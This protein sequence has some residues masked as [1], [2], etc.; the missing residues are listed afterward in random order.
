MLQ[1]LENAPTE[2]LE[3]WVAARKL[4]P[5]RFVA[6]DKIGCW[7]AWMLHG[8]FLPGPNVPTGMRD[9]ANEGGKVYTSIRCAALG[10]NGAWLLIWD[11]GEVRPNLKGQYPALEESLD[12]L[13]GDDI[14]VSEGPPDRGS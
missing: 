4:S 13:S 3:E 2:R 9:A 10:K 12:N 8:D 1:V 7:F 14:T 5:L 6:G 11:D